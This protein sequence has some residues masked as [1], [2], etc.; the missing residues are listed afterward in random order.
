MYKRIRDMRED[1]D[2]SQREIGEAIGVPQRTYSHYENGQ[3]VIP[4]EI[5]IRLAQFHHTSV[6]YI[7]G[8][9]DKREPYPGRR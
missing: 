7:L 8:L 3:R 2:L 4:P 6:D 1:R 9:T 5:L